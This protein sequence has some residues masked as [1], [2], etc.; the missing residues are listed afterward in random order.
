M[1]A[2]TVLYALIGLGLAVGALVAVGQ[3]VDYLTRTRTAPKGK[4]M[5]ELSFAFLAVLLAVAMRCLHVALA[6]ARSTT[7]DLQPD[8]P[9]QTRLYMACH[10]PRCGHMEWPHDRTDEGLRCTHCGELNSPA[11]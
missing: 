7:P 4:P 3:V 9:A 1:T 11:S 5:S 8:S 6:P 2:T 10:R